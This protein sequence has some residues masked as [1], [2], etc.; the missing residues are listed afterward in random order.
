M[1]NVADNEM[2][3]ETLDAFVSAHVIDEERIV[4]ARILR[5][6]H[7]DFIAVALEPGRDVNLPESFRG[8]R[9]LS[10]QREPGYVAAGPLR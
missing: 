7:G 6:E 10:T 2:L 1:L 4:S 9:V 8:L 3:R 5:D